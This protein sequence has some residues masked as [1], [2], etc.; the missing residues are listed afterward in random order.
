[1]N[2]RNNI[3]P[4]LER[5][6]ALTLPPLEIIV[7]DDGSVDGTREYLQAIM[8]HEPRV[9]LLFHE[10]RQTLTTAQLQGIRAA[11]GEYVVIMDADLQHP[12]EIVP[13]ILLDLYRGQTL[14]IA[15]RYCEGGDVGDRSGY[16][17]VLSRGADLIAKLALPEARGVTDP[18][19]GFFGFRRE[20]AHSLNPATRGYK[21]LL[22]L[23]VL[24]RGKGVKETGYKFRPRTSGSSK[25]T[26]DFGFLGAFLT[27]LLVAKRLELWFRS[28]RSRISI[29][30]TPP[31]SEERMSPL[32]QSGAS[33]PGYKSGS[34]PP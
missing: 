1:L 27:E 6:F 21:L 13:E 17:A 30:P 14:A 12:P 28:S 4:L 22:F 24:S 5:L 34:F 11:S 16:R 29:V 32:S 19:S 8:Q 10:G 15:S 25:I 2:E 26:H 18:I 3:A 33:Q 7:V 9:H 31:Q 23:L 20:L